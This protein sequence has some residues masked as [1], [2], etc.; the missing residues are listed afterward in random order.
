MKLNKTKLFVIIWLTHLFVYYAAY[1]SLIAVLQ[2][3]YAHL[4]RAP[5]GFAVG[6]YGGLE[7]VYLFFLIPTILMLFFIKTILK[8]KW[9]LAYAVSICIAYLMNYLWLFL[10]NQDYEIFYTKNSINLLYFIVPSLII[11]VYSN[12]LIFKKKYLKFKV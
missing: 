7:Q 9:F 12:K 2:Q 3:K 11:S 8:N 6:M 1:L 5:F 4:Y 10:N